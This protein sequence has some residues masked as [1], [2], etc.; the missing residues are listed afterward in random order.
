MSQNVVQHMIV[1]S[2]NSMATV[3][4]LCVDRNVK[5]EEKY[6]IIYKYYCKFAELQ[7]NKSLVRYILEM[8]VQFQT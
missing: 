7:C 4:T 3:N 5:E 6:G 2:V 8:L 1:A